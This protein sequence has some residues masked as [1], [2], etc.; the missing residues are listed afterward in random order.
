MFEIYQLGNTFSSNDE[1]AI[2]L[3]SL[4]NLGEKKQSKIVYSIYEVLYLLENKK[5]KLLSKNKEIKFKN[6]LSKNKDTKLNYLVFKDLKNKAYTPK[7]ALRFGADFRV[8]EKGK[9]PGK[10]HAKYLVF[11]LPESEKIKLNN[12]AGKTRIAHSTKKDLLIAIVDSQED[13]TYYQVNW[14]K[15]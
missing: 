9:T 10:A 13:I 14:K 2:S 8:Y 5:A 1:Q 6:L 4:K 7:T 11:V 3:A 15:I 12:L